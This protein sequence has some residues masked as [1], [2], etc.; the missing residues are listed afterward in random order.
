MLS[1]AWWNYNIYNLQCFLHDSSLARQLTAVAN[2]AKRSNKSAEQMVVDNQY[3]AT[4]WTHKVEA[5]TDVCRQLQAEGSV[6]SGF[7]SIFLT[8]AP[9]EWN[10]PLHRG[11]LEWCAKAKLLSNS[12]S[13]L[14]LHIYNAL[15][16]VLQAVFKD[17]ELLDDWGIKTIFEFAIRI[18]FQKRGTPHAHVIIWAASHEGRDM[19]HL[20]GRSGEDHTS[21]M[22]TWFEKTF[23]CGAVDIQTEQGSALLLRYVAGY[24]SKASDALHYTPQDKTAPS[25]TSAAIW[26]T[27]FRLLSRKGFTEQ[28]M[29]VEFASLPLVVSSFTSTVVYAPVPGSPAVNSSRRLYAAYLSQSDIKDQTYAAWAREWTLQH[30]SGKMDDLQVRRRNI[31]GR[32]KGKRCAVA[33]IFPFELL[34]IFIGAFALTTFPGIRETELI[35]PDEKDYPIG[36][37]NLR[38]VLKHPLID[39]DLPKLIHLVLKDMM[40]RGLS[41]D[42]MSTFSARTRACELLLKRTETGDIDPNDWEAKC[43]AK[44]PAFFWSEK[45]QAFL[46]SF[47]HAMLGEDE[48]ACRIISLTG[49]P[50]T[51]KTEVLLEAVRRGLDDGCKVLLAGPIGMLIANHRTRL[52]EHHNLTIETIHA[53]FKITRDRDQEYIPPGR[54]RHYDLIFMDEVSQIDGGIWRNIMTALQELTPM[55]VLVLAG[56]WQQLQ[57]VRGSGSLK[58]DLQHAID[59]GNAV[60]IELVQHSRARS[61]DGDLLKFLHLCRT[62]QPSRSALQ[63]FFGSRILPR[64]IPDCL[65]EIAK[66]EK[67]RDQSMTFLTVTNKAAAEFNLARIQAD[68]PEIVDKEGVQGDPR[69][70]SYEL[71]IAKGMRIRLTRNMDKEAGFTNGTTGTVD[72]VLHKWA[73]VLKVDNGNKLLVY[74]LFNGRKPFLPCSYAYACTMRRAQGANMKLI[75]LRF[76]HWH[77]DPGYAYVATSRATTKAGVYHVGK[78]RRKDWVPVGAPLPRELDESDDEQEDSEEESDCRD[79]AE[80]DFD[81]EQEESE[82]EDISEHSDDDAFTKEWRAAPKIADVDLA[83]FFD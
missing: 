21:P 30:E 48:R 56:D 2:L 61:S 41:Q 78:L 3:F 54:L 74:P 63:R 9:S 24:L 6:G 44:P 69:V 59:K 55:P 75:A 12:H 15:T 20:S 31:A 38:A 29:A 73:F 26:R 68:F 33:M 10:F 16:S 13:L 64:N 17:R 25:K 51:G 4:F 11:M 72:I 45:Q 23:S 57:P 36:T 40:L 18:E 22:V 43:I 42:R 46:R 79:D 34:D 77:V 60:H 66:I 35:L 19:A 39:N 58:H 71:K 81:H 67:A 80:E 70:V 76:D 5:L 7:P 50:G 28:E 53:A 32:G 27:V 82:E 52:S 62:N 37:R 65:E 49:G 14:T 83:D 1:R 47:M 8:I